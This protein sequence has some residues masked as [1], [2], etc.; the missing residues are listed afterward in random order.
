MMKVIFLDIDGVLVTRKSLQHDHDTIT[1]PW[2]I[3][4]ARRT[5]LALS[6]F[7][8][9]AVKNLNWLIE[10]SGAGLVISSVWR[11]Y[12]TVGQLREIF[13]EE[14][15]EGDVLGA[16]MILRDDDRTE[17]PRGSE[18]QWWLHSNPGVEGF[19]ILD[20]DSYDIAPLFPDRLVK[21]DTKIGLTRESAELAFSIINT[22]LEG[23]V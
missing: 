23:V 15:V 1:Q 11:I 2:A 8:P 4:G 14:G 13:A 10:A 20:D 22:K 3:S 5:H 12:R 21:L 7:D 19:C 16:T 18:I 6:S 17:Y 9:E